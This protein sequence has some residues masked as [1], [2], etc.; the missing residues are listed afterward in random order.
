LT[1]VAEDSSAEPMP[2]PHNG[3]DP[4]TERTS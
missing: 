3:L 2:L 1:F 4:T